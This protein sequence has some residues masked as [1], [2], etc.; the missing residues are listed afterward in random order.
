MPRIMYGQGHVFNDYYTSGGNDYCVG[1][2]SYG[3]ALLENNY[4]KNV[5]DPHCFMYDVYC[6]MTA[7]GNEYDNTTG[8]KDNGKGGS[9]V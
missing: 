7:K 4:F 2:G 8:K 3:A 1:V 6:W 5:K 9:K